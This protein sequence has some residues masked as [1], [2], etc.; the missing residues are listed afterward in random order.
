MKAE[1]IR[2]MP[3]AAMEEIKAAVA[4]ATDHEHGLQLIVGGYCAAFLEVA[5]EAAA[6]LAEANEHL[7]KIANPWSTAD[8]ESLVVWTWLTSNGKPFAIDCR[9]V[10]GVASL[11][12]GIGSDHP[13]VVIGM[14]GQP[15]SK[16]A[17]GTVEEICS[18]LGIPQR[19]EKQQ[20]QK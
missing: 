19:R 3:L 6:Q 9:E 13:T 2:K 4:T 10:T 1:E 11:D 8:Q 7:A 16:S 12:T 18:K 14:K 5:A 15:W 17:D 20:W